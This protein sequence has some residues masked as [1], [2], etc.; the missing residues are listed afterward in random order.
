MNSFPSITSQN[1]THQPKSIAPNFF[2]QTQHPNP[3]SGIPLSFKLLNDPLPWSPQ[4][5]HMH[6]ENSTT[7]KQ[8]TELFNFLT[9]YEDL[10][11]SALDFPRGEDVRSGEKVLHEMVQKSYDWWVF[12]ETRTRNNGETKVEILDRHARLID[13]NMFTFYLQL[14]MTFF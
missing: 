10:A 3:L 13:V 14:F 8:Y 1:S 5:V 11:T 6:N 9:Y 2:P 4:T 12:L 7:S